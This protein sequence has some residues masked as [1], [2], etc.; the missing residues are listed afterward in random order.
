[1]KRESSSKVYQ[2]GARMPGQRRAGQLVFNN[3]KIVREFGG[4]RQVLRCQVANV[5]FDMIGNAATGSVCQLPK[6][7]LHD[8]S[9]ESLPSCTEYKTFKKRHGYSKGRRSLFRGPA[10]A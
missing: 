8:E 9:A 4:F 1:M 7:V 3:L 10:E 6:F 5:L 2:R